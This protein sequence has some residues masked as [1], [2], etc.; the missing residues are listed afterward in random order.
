MKTSRQAWTAQGN[1]YPFTL[2]SQVGQIVL[3]SIPSSSISSSGTKRRFMWG[4][5]SQSA[6]TLL[7]GKQ[8]RSIS[9]LP[10][11]PYH[12]QTLMGTLGI[13]A[14]RYLPHSNPKV[15][16]FPQAKFD[17][18]YRSS[19]PELSHFVTAESS[20]QSPGKHT[21]GGVYE[22][23]VSR[24]VAKVGGQSWT[25]AVPS[26]DRESGTKLKRRSEW[27]Q[28]SPLSL[29]NCEQSGLMPHMPHPTP[30]TIHSSRDPT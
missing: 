18:P 5:L 2:W 29:P 17:F 11:S 16:S 12:C 23:C 30:W 8:S 25:G 3:V 21:S 1:I 4:Q 6:F 28:R 20:F 27:S 13:Y 10:L 14:L 19:Y 15:V 24:E 22:A 26:H 7:C 9:S